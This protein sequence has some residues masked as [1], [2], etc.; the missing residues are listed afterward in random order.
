MD[1]P[2]A[3]FPQELLMHDHRSILVITKGK[4]P[5][6]IR[7]SS[8]RGGSN[9]WGQ[10]AALHCSVDQSNEVFKGLSG[11]IWVKTHFSDELSNWVTW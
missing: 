7:R 5:P 1:F 3:T 11:L 10:T 8:F 9:F 4:V 2:E 6:G